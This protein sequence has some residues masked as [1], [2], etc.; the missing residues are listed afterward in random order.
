MALSTAASPARMTARAF[1][2]VARAAASAAFAFSKAARS[3][4]TVASS[5]VMFVRSWS[6]CSPATSSCWRSVR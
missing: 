3:A 4:C 6:Y 2:I 5:A 1:S